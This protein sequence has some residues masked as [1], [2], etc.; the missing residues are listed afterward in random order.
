MVRAILR[1]I[2]GNQVEV[3]W[4]AQE[5]TAQGAADRAVPAAGK[6]G[7][8]VVGAGTTGAGLRAGVPAV[9]VPF[10]MDQ[11]FWGSRVA[12]LGVGPPPVPLGLR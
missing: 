6:T 10:A 4:L 12:A 5:G 1:I 7:T 11:G 8:A 9:V 2:E 3:R